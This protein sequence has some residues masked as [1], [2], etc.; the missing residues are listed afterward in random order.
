[1]RRRNLLFGLLAVATLRSARAE[2]SRKANRIAIALSAG[3]VT[4]ISDPQAALFQ[5]SST[6]SVGRDMSRETIS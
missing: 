6:N 5:R 2:Q 4:I 1:M 3:S